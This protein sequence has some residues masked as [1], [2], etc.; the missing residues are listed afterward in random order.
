M[1]DSIFPSFQTS[2]GHDSNRNP[3]QKWSED[4]ASAQKWDGCPKSKHL[5]IILFII[6]LLYCY[7]CDLIIIHEKERSV[8]VLH[9]K[10]SGPVTYKIP[11]D[12][13]LNTRLFSVGFVG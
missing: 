11:F 12:T 1:S 7:L 3:T 13:T 10:V 4:A 9:Q 5:I 2:I 8:T 6:I